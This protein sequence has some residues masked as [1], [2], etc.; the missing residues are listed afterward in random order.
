MPSGTAGLSRGQRLQQFLDMAGADSALAKAATEAIG[1]LSEAAMQISAAIALG[2]LG[3]A[4]GASAGSTNAAGDSQTALDVLAHKLCMDA[5]SRTSTAFFASEEEDAILTLAPGGLLAVAVDPLDGS[6]NID[7]NVP[8]GTIFSILPA[9]PGGATGSL[10]RPGSEQIAAGYF[11]Y[12]PQT[13]LVV[14]LGAGAHHFV[15]DR[16]TG[17]FKLARANIQIP[18]NSTEYAINASNYRHWHEPIRTFVDDCIAGAE[19]PRGKDFNMRWVA[20]L[21]AEAHRIFC[22]GG[23]FLY[24]ADRRAGY[25]KGRLRL[26][27]EAAPIA[28]LAKEAGG[29]ATDGRTDILAKAPGRLHERTPLI[30]GSAEKVLRLARYH[31]D[32]GFLHNEPPLFGE[33]GLFRS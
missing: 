15:L 20:S 5:L 28:M 7:V 24:P 21:V 9:A 2:E 17:E 1:A 6:S 18:R 25:E 13:A 3:G 32:P 4:L 10:F 31:A 19:G 16:G 30:F 26:L 11:I 22:R 8:T 33:R 29:G 27:Y 14:T 23:V 12:G